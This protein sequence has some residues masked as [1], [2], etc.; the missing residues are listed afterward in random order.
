M[1][2]TAPIIALRRS[3]SL[4][5]LVF[6]G[7]GVTVGAGIFA[8]IGEVVSLAGDFAPMSFLIA[9]AVA[10]FTGWSYVLLAGAHPRAAGEAVF[11]KLGLGSAVGRTVGYGVVAVAITAGVTIGLAFAGYLASF[12]GIPEPVGL[13]AVLILLAVIAIAGVR[14]SVGFAAVVTVLEVGTLLVVI[15]VALPMFGET[16]VTA[17]ITALPG[18]HAAMS[19][20]VA[21]AFVVFFAFIGF[22]N[23]ENMA[24]ETTDSHR[25]VPLATILTLAISVALYGLVACVAVAFPDRVGFTSS[26]APLAVLFSA[27]TGWPGAPIAA[28]AS[29]A[30]VNGILV[31]IIMAS[32]VLYGMSRE[33]QLP[34]WFEVLHETR[35]T[36]TRAILLVTAATAALPL[37]VPLLQLAELTS[38]VML[39]IYTTVNVSLF[40]IG[41]SKAAPER[42]RRWRYWGLLGAAISLGLIVAE[43]AR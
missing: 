16:G 17:R 26:K 11:A 14:E 37:S 39:L 42:I 15:A 7:V 31:Q 24:E 40:S 5:W 18:S 41:C 3:L 8:L 25:T 36:P 2:N 4:P 32:R 43:L 13:V 1:E 29:I 21:G 27:A 23:I 10:G 35:Q 28:M 6:Y 20:V 38:L 12:T 19:S 34:P 30:M 22:K 9:G 33:A